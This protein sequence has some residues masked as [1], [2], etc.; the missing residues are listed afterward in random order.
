MCTKLVILCSANVY[1]GVTT[2]LFLNTTKHT[3]F[4]E[5]TNKIS[6]FL[7]EILIYGY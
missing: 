4:S 2:A 7:H 6:K 1:L 5:R 3:M